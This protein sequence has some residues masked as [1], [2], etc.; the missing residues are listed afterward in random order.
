MADKS[1][2]V[3]ITSRFPYPT[4]KGDK[5]R[6]YQQIKQLKQLGHSIYL[7][8]LSDSEITTEHLAEMEKYCSEIKTFRIG[9][10]QIFFN[11]LFGIFKLWP[12]QVSYFYSAAIRKKIKTIVYKINPDVVFFQLIRTA[13]IGR[14]HV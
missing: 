10:F 8:S 5:L 4:E 1:S 2:I 12:F 6:A 9:K 14:A 11:L 7:V 3:F 13:Q